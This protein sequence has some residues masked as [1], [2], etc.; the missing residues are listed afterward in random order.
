MSVTAALVKELREKS[1]AGMM[2]CKKALSETDGDM[3]A[4]ID[5]L[6][7]KGLATAAKKSGRVASEGLVAF[8]V[9]GTRG[10]LIELNAETDF[11]ARNTEFQEFASTLASLALNAD[12]IDALGGVDYPGTGRNVSEELTH[13]IA[14][15]GENMSLRRM[16]TVSVGAGSVV[17]YMHN[18]TAPGLGRI[19][20]LVALESSADAA[21]L[22]ELGKQIAMHIA[23]TSPASL[24]V[25]D[26]DPES[27]QRE[28]DVLIE[29]AKASGKPQEIAE[30]MVEGRMKKYYQEVVLLEQTS[31]IDGET[32]IAGVV[33]NAAKSAG[34]DIELKAFARF[35]LGEGIEKEETDFAA[36]VAAQL[37]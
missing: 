28:R 33:A 16:E 10:A 32:Q 15:I 3:E 20:V 13:K 14:T 8:A 30:K 24:S 34:T 26:L 27:V 37:S 31:V 35:N 17:S 21:V 25:N 36:E 6:R 29:Q 18:S 19:G 4:A 5:W 23:A 11:V 7:T 12:D 2:D 22:E 1:G 9:D